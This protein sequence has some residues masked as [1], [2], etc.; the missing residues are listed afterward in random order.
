MN[1]VFVGAVEGS[2]AALQ[3]ICAAGHLPRL[4]VTLPPDLAHR[5]SDYADLAPLAAQYGIPVH[6]AA[7]SNAPE[8][9]AAIAATEPDLALVI[10]WSQL[11]REEF[12]ALPRLGCIGFHPADLPR[13]R[14]RAVIPWAILLGEREMGSSLF[15]IDEGTDTGDIA[16]K[17]RFSVDPD[18]VTARELYDRHLAALAEML[19]DLLSRIAAGEVPRRPQ[20]ERGASLCARRRAEDG[21]IDW[22][23]PAAGIHRL[24]RAVGPP[25][26][27]AF[28]EDAAGNRL[29][30]TAVRF[31]PREGYYI[32]LP[33]Q[34][35]AIDGR[36]FTVCCGDGRCLD[37]LDWTGADSPPRLHTSL[38][39]GRT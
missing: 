6:Y 2:R 11:V 24:I 26:P 35:Q 27:G 18:T 20:D 12:R 10:G 15:W 5:H 8:T 16:A 4:V 30:L 23:L 21:R 34:V 7:N 22:S 36:S 32:G 9:I 33:G 29:V 13:L 38:G 39:K 1:I 19:P 25:Y 14:G 37:I 17:A 28:T 3:A 31:T